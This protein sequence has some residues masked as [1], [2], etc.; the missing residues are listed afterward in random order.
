[1]SDPTGADLSARLGRALAPAYE[2]ESELGRGGMAI[3][4]RGRD[5]RLKRGVAVKLLPPDLAFRA[6]IRSRFLRE[7]E[8]A[9]RLSHP[10]I[11]PIYSVDER[12]GLVYFVMA[13]V[14]G[15]SV[16]DRIRR[17]GAM[18]IADTRRIVREVAD[19]LATAHANGVV[20]RDIKPDNILLD[21][22]SG[23]A[24]VTDFGIARA[25]SEEG[26]GSRL[27]ATGAA[28]GTPAYMSPE[29]CLGDRDI[30]GRSDL[31]SLGAVA[32]QM[33]TGEPPFSGTNTPSIMMKQVTERPV[34]LRE[35]RRDVPEDFERI[36]MRL[37]EKDP[38]NR[39]ADG[40]ALVAALD[41][42]PFEAPAEPL[43]VAPR[44]APTL[45]VEFESHR[46]SRR[47]ER[48]LRREARRG[49]GPVS[50]AERLRRMR[51]HLVSYAGTSAMLFGINAMTGRGFWWCV[52][53]IMAMG[54]GF[55]KELGS[56]WADG[57]PLG[58]IFSGSLPVHALPAAES[59]TLTRSAPLPLPDMSNPVLAGTYGQVLRQ[60]IVDRR[61]ILDLVGRLNASELALIPDVKGTA[62]ALYQRIVSLASALHRLDGQVDERR[63]AEL[64]ERI[65]Q[66]ER[67][68]GAGGDQERRLNLLRRQR[69]MIDELARSRDSLVE[70]Y[71]SAG[72]LLQN[73]ALDLLKMRSSGIDAALGGLTSAT[74]EARA[75]SREIGYVLRAA[76]ELR[77]LEGKR[78]AES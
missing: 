51:N 14:H 8:T 31:Y 22:Q 41:G 36:I 19:A 29:Q 27:T 35:R 7:A 3:V 64:G 25:A 26:G 20:H 16:G 72:I 42:E 15:E 68:P 21:E 67:Q 58:S 47:E 76:D 1:M 34:P 12:D 49:R 18:S 44:P 5:A 54:V 37:L 78:G 77:D 11:V 10:N 52:F 6:D 57:M 73:L 46:L 59:P 70:Q 63:G 38:A 24:M 39:F 65:A 43:P 69:D 30:D 55:A 28:I 17:T 56:F 48:A 66:I 53:P 71:E 50:P 32:Y 40:S 74:Q 33:L 60:A 2:I 61:N 4:Y 9:A 75:L 62:E 13:L 45:P 23:R